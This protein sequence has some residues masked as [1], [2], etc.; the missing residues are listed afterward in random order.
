MNKLSKLH[1]K[2]YCALSGSAADAQTI[3]EVV[4]YQL[5][6]HRYASSSWTWHTLCAVEVLN[7]NNT[8]KS[9]LSSTT[10]FEDLLT[11]NPFPESIFE[12]S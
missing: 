9:E 1:D 4:N 11:L 8:E 3:A 5:D 12:V 10:V 2:I 6:V 7:T